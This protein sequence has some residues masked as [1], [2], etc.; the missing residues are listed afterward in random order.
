MESIKINTFQN[1]Q[2][3]YRLGGMGNRILA[4][5]LDNVVRF[6][7]LIIILLILGGT[8]FDKMFSF[9]RG[10]GLVVFLAL[11]LFVILPLLFYSLI[12]EIFMNGQTP[13]K[14]LLFLKVARLDGRPVQ[15]WQYILRWMFLILDNSTLGLLPM[16]LSRYDQRF[17]D[18]LA[19][20][21]VISLKEEKKTD[22]FSG[23]RFPE[24][25]VPVFPEAYQL[26]DRDI[27]I[28]KDLVNQF[29]NSGSDSNTLLV[30]AAQKLKSILHVEYTGSDLG[31]IQQIIKD[32]TYH[33]EKSN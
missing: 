22:I 3:S 1:I 4:R 11:W 29:H 18:L 25:Y 21:T 26:S 13:G 23:M 10:A 32:Y 5:I 31:F 33:Y 24:N 6:S 27:S 2:V 14:R 12:F 7:Y 8:V 20:T 28:V 19:G 17:G 30:K 16:A 15:I 9:P